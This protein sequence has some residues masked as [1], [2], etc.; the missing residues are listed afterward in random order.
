VRNFHPQTTRRF[1]PAHKENA[2]KTRGARQAADQRV[3][4]L[5]RAGKVRVGVFPPQY[6]KDP[7]TGE[8]RSV[9]VEIA[10]A[11]AM[12]IGVQ[13]VFLERPTPSEA[14]AC[15]KAGACD[16]LFLPFDTRAGEV[17]GFSSPFIEFDFTYLVPDGSLI[18]SIADA[19]RPGIRIAV[20][21]NHAST[22][23]LNRVLKQAKLVYAET[24]DPTFDLLR[25]G[26]A[27]VMAS[28]RST[29]LEY[30]TKLPGSRV[31]KDRYGATLSRLV[32]PKDQAGWLEYVSE[33]VEEAKA[34]GLVQQAIDRV[35][36]RGVQVA[37]PGDSPAQ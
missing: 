8:L 23:A 4:D 1:I 6:T 21:R 32:V 28:A 2:M 18:Q 27:D 33:F 16:L 34:S 20:V 36:P 30:S 11:L 25:T 24:P 3:A 22:A 17:G 5:V 29:L 19:D 14:V 12:R 7:V 31:L 26:D 13:V 37:P 9:W 35:G 15:L 10:R